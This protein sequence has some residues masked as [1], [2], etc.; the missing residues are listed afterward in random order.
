M[1]QYNDLKEKAVSGATPALVFEFRLRRL[2]VGGG[3]KLLTLFENKQVNS[4]Y[5]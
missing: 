4:T 5:Y 1:E 2:E 3:N